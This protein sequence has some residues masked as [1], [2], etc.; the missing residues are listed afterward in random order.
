MAEPGLGPSWSQPLGWLGK[1]SSSYFSSVPNNNPRRGIELLSKHRW[2]RW[3]C[4]SLSTHD[5]LA[6]LALLTCK[7][8]GIGSRLRSCLGRSLSCLTALFVVL[9]HQGD[10]E[11]TEA[12]SYMLAFHLTNNSHQAVSQIGYFI[13]QRTELIK[14]AWT[15]KRLLNRYTLLI[16]TTHTR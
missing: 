12:G 4:L 5:C 8:N 6:L 16:T 3:R 10:D 14:S 1:A 13:Q 15:H 7:S 9:T 11:V 2:F